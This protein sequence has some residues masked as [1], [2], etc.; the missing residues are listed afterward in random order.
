MI[1]GQPHPLRRA[2]SRIN[3]A[4][5]QRAL[6]E[7]CE[8]AGWPYAEAWSPSPDGTC[9][10]LPAWYAGDSGLAAF[11]RPTEAL[12]FMPRVGLPS[13]VLRFK[14]VMFVADVTTDPLFCRRTAAR[15]A[16]LLGRSG[17]RSLPERPWLPYSSSSGEQSRFRP[18]RSSWGLL[19]R[20]RAAL[21]PCP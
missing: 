12:Q 1:D 18:G 4:G 10:L 17:S 19:R 15:R 5:I 21:E 16:G 14:R 8:Q 9:Q 6:Q 20:P 7:V 11:R 2:S 13:R 3:S